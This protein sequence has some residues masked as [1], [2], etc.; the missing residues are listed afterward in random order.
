[1]KILKWT[2]AIV[3]LIGLAQFLPKTERIVESEPQNAF[4]TDNEQLGSILKSACYD[5][6]SNTPEFPWYAS[7]VPL[8]YWIDNHITEG[9]EHL[10]FSEW[11]RLSEAD[12]K[13]Q[14]EEIVEVI[15]EEEMPLT[16]YTIM[17]AEAR[18]SDKERKLIIEFFGE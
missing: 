6:H 10:N 2:A 8:N 18:L 7:I 17:H 16:S 9:R 3:L 15:E 12:K 11:E 13:H 14:R 4:S 5:C 1:M